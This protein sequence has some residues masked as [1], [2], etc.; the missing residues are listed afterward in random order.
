MRCQICPPDRTA[1]GCVEFQRLHGCHA[2]DRR[3]C[4]H[5]NPSCRYYTRVRESHP[6]ATMGDS[7]P[8]MRETRITCTAGGLNMEGRLH[9]NWWRQSND[10]RFSVDGE[11]PFSMGHASGDQCNC[12]IDTLRQVLDLECDIR[13][14]RAFV[15]ARHANLVLGDYLELQQ[16]WRDVISGLAHVLLGPAP[17]QL[18]A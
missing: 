9:V 2:C 7:V 11:G 13:A 16:H 4:W 14:V 8:H 12:L 3:G 1:E 18:C 15:Q 6:D 5:A 10:V 17:T